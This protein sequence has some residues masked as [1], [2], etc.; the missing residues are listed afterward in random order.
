MSWTQILG[1]V[2]CGVLGYWLVAVLLPLLAKSR[3]GYREPHW[4][5]D[6]DDIA[7]IQTRSDTA[8]PADDWPRVLGVRADASDA[9]ITAAYRCA[10]DD[11]DPQRVANTGVDEVMLEQRA[12]RL[13]AALASALRSRGR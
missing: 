3:D 2:L 7:A 8:A 9:E 10:I 12:A 11:C 13:Q 4:P 6:A 5:A 1:I